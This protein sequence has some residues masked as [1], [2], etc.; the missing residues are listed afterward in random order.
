MLDTIS[1]VSSLSLLTTKRIRNQ[2]YEILE[3]FFEKSFKDYGFEKKFIPENV[4]FA[5][6]YFSPH[7]ITRTKLGK[8]YL[9]ISNCF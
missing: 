5:E 3:S 8:S 2:F 1:K 6:D 9:Y 7:A 4:P